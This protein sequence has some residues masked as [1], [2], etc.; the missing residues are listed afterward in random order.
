MYV[1]NRLLAD[2]P[3]EDRFAR[4]ALDLAA[5]DKLAVTALDVPHLNMQPTHHRCKKRSSKKFLKRLKT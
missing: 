4:L 1:D 5:P 3:I 2:V